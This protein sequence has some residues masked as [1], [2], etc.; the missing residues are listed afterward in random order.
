MV[1][2]RDELVS[3]Q[4]PLPTR[5]VAVKHWG[6][7]VRVR[8]LTSAESERFDLALARTRDKE[9]G[10]ADIENVRARHVITA[11]VSEDGKPLFT[12]A[13]LPWLQSQPD[14]VIDVLYDAIR[15]LSKAAEG[16]LGNSKTPTA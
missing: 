4:R 10:V 7:S 16:D 6:G 9:T 2:S 1:L 5:D 3:V 14:G 15:A 12:D 13:D 11:T 8:S